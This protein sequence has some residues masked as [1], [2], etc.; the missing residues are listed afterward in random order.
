MIRGF[1]IKDNNCDPLYLS[2]LFN[3]YEYTQGNS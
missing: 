2:A 1:N 3:T